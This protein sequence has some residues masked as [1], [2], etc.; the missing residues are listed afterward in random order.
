MASALAFNASRGFDGL[1]RELVETDEQYVGLIRAV[2]AVT[3]R[4]VEAQ[5]TIRHACPL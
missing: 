3:Y 1:G 2:H 5:I 4:T